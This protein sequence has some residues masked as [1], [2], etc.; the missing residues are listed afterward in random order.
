MTVSIGLPCYKE[1]KDQGAAAAVEKAYPGLSVAALPN[2][3]VTISVNL[4]A[5]PS[6][7]TADELIT[8]L[9]LLKNII[10]GGVF[11]QYF[12][13]VLTGS[14]PTPAPFTFSLRA[15][16]TL[17]F[18][19]K[20]DR[21][22]VVFS[23]DFTDATDAAIAK[24]FMQEFVEAKRRLGS[25]PPCTFS[26]NPPLELTAFNVTSASDRLGYISFAVLKNHLEGGKKEKVIQVLQVFR[27]YLQYHIKCSK[28]YFHQRMRLRVVNLLK[29]LSR[30]KLETLPGEEKEKK[31]ITGKTFIRS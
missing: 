31:T 7:F 28:S 12:S 1:I 20:P 19:P 23:L 18:I 11:D 29:V 26:H 24:I 27:N 9:S 13:A 3:D 8:R 16:T 14:T 15:D 17:Y 22:T 10:I 21:V 2:Y 6:T 25:A 4:T 5:L 30:A